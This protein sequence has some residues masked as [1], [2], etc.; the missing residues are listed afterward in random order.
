MEQT[1]GQ[2][3][4]SVI[5]PVY[6]V[7][8]YLTECINSII[9][10]DFDE[11][12][13]ICVED[14]SRDKSAHVLGQIAKGDSR[15]R[16]INHEANR[17][18]S[19]ARNTG[20][21]SA[22]GKYVQFVDADDILAPNALRRLYQEAENQDV[23][24]VYFN[25][26][27][28]EGA[29]DFSKIETNILWTNCSRV[30]SGREMFCEMIEKGEFKCEAV[31]QFIRRDFLINK[32]IRFYERI[33]HEDNLFSYY[34]AMEAKRVCN[35][36]EEF[37]F[38]RQHENSIMFTKDERRAQS[39]FVVLEN[40]FVY[41]RTHAFTERENK[42][43]G[44]MWN[45]LVHLYKLYQSYGNEI[46]LQYG[47]F[48]D[49]TIYNTLTNFQERRW[50]NI[51][52]ISLIQLQ[53]FKYVYVYG[54]G[55]AAKQVVGYL[56]ENRVHIDGI[57]VANRKKNPTLFCGLRVYEVAEYSQK[58]SDTIVIIG[59]TSKYLQ[60]IKEILQSEGFFNTIQLEDAN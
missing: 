4:I 29:I 52:E 21:E 27:K 37:Y 50:L 13:I 35:I 30:Y 15:I 58:K 60:E 11:I 40:I 51:E 12:E 9:C 44:I 55:Q 14:C 22:R 2:I 5:I 46:E 34:V 45:D 54:A 41:W 38:Y 33:V 59:V 26:L 42:Y 20:L 32:K 43:I 10:Q 8:E 48:V 28:F 56:K 39:L 57:L 24:V 3:K 16:I 18:L 49:I 25:L 17:G 6:N 47:D 7:E 31:R 53:K 36:N 19:A 23:D 1:E